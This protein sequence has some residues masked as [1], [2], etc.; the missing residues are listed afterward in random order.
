MLEHMGTQQT[1]SKL[2]VGLCVQGYRGRL[3]LW[4]AYCDLSSECVSFKCLTTKILA[5]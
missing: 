1:L 4:H 3:K 2:Q 5:P